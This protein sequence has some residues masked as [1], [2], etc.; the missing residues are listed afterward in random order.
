MPHIL[1]TELKTQMLMEHGNS[2][3]RRALVRNL[4]GN[5]VAWLEAVLSDE[6]MEPKEALERKN[7]LDGP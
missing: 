2:S 3:V 5:D 6:L 7:G 4:P 1:P